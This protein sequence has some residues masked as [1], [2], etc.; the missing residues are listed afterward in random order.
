MSDHL[1]SVSQKK[2][3]LKSMKELDMH[4]E[5]IILFEKMYS[6][7]TK[8][9]YTHGA[10]ELGRD[11]IIS[12][13]DPIRMKNTAVVVKMDKIS[14]TNMDKPIYDIVGQV[15]QCFELSIEPKDSFSK[16]AID[17]VFIIVIGEISGNASV[18]LDTKL[19]RFKGRYTKL[20]VNDILDYFDKHYPD[21]FYGASGLH[22]LNEKYDK[23][24]AALREKKYYNPNCYIEPN[25]K[26]FDK[27]KQEMIAISTSNDEKVRSETINNNLFGKRETIDSLGKKI[28]HKQHNILIEGDA[29]SGKSIFSS[30][31][32]QHLIQSAVKD[33]DRHTKEIKVPVLIK[34]TSL[35]N[36]KCNDLENMIDSYYNKSAISYKVGLLIIDGLD[37]VSEQN[38]VD[39]INLSSKICKERAISLLLTSRKSTLTR[40]LVESFEKFEL[41][42]FE[43]SQ[44]INFI[45]KMVTNNQTLLSALLHGIG[46]LKNQIPMYPMALALL[47]EIVEKQG[48]VPASITEL[49]SQY[50]DIA[51]GKYAGLNEISMLFEPAIKHN[52]LQEL[53]FELFYKHDVTFIYIKEFRLFLEDYSQRHS[54]ISDPEAFMSDLMRI[55]I[56]QIKH[57]IVEFSHKSFLDYFVSSYYDKNTLHLYKNNA[58]DNIYKCYH[59]VLWEDVLGFF[60]GIKKKIEKE[61]IEKI[62]SYD[63]ENNPLMSALHKFGIGKLMQYAWQSEI[64][65]KEHAVRTGI[66]DIFALKDLLYI[67]QKNYFEMD[68]PKIVSDVSLMHLINQAYS[69]MFLENEIKNIIDSSITKLGSDQGNNE[70]IQIVYFGS[71]YIVANGKSLSNDYIK[72]FINQFL[73]IE[74]KLNIEVLLPVVTLLKALSIHQNIGDDKGKLKDSLQMVQRRLIKKYKMYSADIFSFKNKKDKLR[75]NELIEKKSK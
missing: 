19:S 55:S 39:I 27:S 4:K 64:A 75:L 28:I 15:E 51:I 12:E 32:I 16:L 33:L 73:S 17:H 37:E 68:L 3:I 63:P 18:N 59:S 45:K 69:S 42:A 52:F 57:D 62:I 26:S 66:E 13:E 30:K 56:L 60:F 61:D 20:D 31:L 67:N 48:E 72:T 2:E 58:F 34:A 5:L 43:E 22:V 54:E 36:G 1:L 10:G 49:Y 40:K 44:A 21:V 53:A 6:K 29:G 8:I 35:K 41:V 14:G 74:Q 70:D 23:I 24:E 46:Q 25:L 11:I 65:V 38:Q 71:L 47:I 7:N 50:I 9:H